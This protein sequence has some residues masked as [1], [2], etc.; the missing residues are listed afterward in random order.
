MM[1][2]KGGAPQSSKV[3]VGESLDQ[4]VKARVRPLAIDQIWELF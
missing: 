1:E 3:V 4:E 2:E